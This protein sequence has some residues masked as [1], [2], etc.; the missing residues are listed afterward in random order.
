MQ[1]TRSLSNIIYSYPSLDI[2][3]VFYDVP[4]F[5]YN[6]LDNN[7]LEEIARDKSAV[8]KYEQ[9]LFKKMLGNRQIINGLTD[10]RL[11]LPNFAVDFVKSFNVSNN[12][13]NILVKDGVYITIPLKG[14]F[15]FIVKKQRGAIFEGQ[16]VLNGN[17]DKFKLY[18]I[19][20]SYGLEDYS[21]AFR[22]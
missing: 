8:K 12:I 22:K 17:L 14:V 20:D 10:S 2:L 18:S 1:I 4:S 21:I 13:D 19:A 6:V 11:M 9:L 5:L 3:S 16:I 7:A 15:N